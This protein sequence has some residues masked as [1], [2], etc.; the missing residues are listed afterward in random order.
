[1][2]RVRKHGE[3]RSNQYCN[4]QF[5]RRI[6]CKRNVM[7]RKGTRLGSCYERDRIS[8]RETG[9][10]QC[11]KEIEIARSREEVGAKNSLYPAYRTAFAQTRERVLPFPRLAGLRK[12]IFR[13]RVNT[14]STW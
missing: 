13:K 14:W 8:S 4:N 2:D 7:A 12:L 11:K 1:M 10:E 6:T 9:A 5:S 3:S